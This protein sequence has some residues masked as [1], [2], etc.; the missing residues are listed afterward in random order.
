MVFR[1][2]W[3]TGAGLVHRAL[4]KNTMKPGYGLLYP[5]VWRARP[6]FLD[7]DVNMHLNNAS[8]LYNMELARWHFSAATGI[9][10]E[11]VKKRQ[12]F[13]VG[14]QSIRY[15]HPIPPFRPYEI[16]TQVVYWDDSWVYFLHH[17]QCPTTGKLYAEGLCRATVK[18]GKRRVSGQELYYNA[19]GLMV[20]TPKELLH[21]SG[22][23]GSDRKGGLMD[24]RKQRRLATAA[25]EIDNDSLSDDSHVEITS[26]PPRRHSL[27]L[28]SPL[29]AARV[30]SVD[31][32]DDDDIIE[33]IEELDDDPSAREANGEASA[34]ATNVGV[35]DALINRVTAR[36]VWIAGQCDE[37]QEAC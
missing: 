15:R 27:A 18:E 16:R 2:F 19:T 37:Q 36:K 13:L 17:F 7:C 11:A 22:G 4:N 9:V 28:E 1:I 3:N 23:I 5:A 20:D 31:S 25:I 10:H 12:M 24:E 26:P 30:T 35:E 34:I 6:G 33:Q 14:S 32:G 8:Y 29:A 21:S